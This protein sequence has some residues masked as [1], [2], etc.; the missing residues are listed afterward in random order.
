MCIL[1][2]G[3][4]AKLVMEKLEGDFFAFRRDKEHGELYSWEKRGRQ[5]ALDIALALAYLHA[6]KII[7]FDI[8]SSASLALCLIQLSKQPRG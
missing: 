2:Q 5:V 6:R 8:K 3:G 7:H 1:W 4:K